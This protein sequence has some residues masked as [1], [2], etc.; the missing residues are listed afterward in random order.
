MNRYRFALLGSLSAIISARLYVG[1][2]GSLNFS[3]L[4]HELHHFYYGISL[5]IFAG[6]LKRKGV[7]ELLIFF[8]VGLGLGYIFDEFDLLLSF[9]KPYTMRLYDNPINISMDTILIL[10]FFRL[11]QTHDR[12]YVNGLLYD[13][14]SAL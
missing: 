3:F 7:S 12:V 5:L 11:N 6:I 13:S 8:I 1:F 14:E 10:I 9:G 4:G 2:G